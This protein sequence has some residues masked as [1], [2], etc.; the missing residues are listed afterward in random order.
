MKSLAPFFFCL[1][2]VASAPASADEFSDFRIPTHAWRSG[3]ADL[4]LSGHRDVADAGF[5]SDRNQSLVSDLSGRIT[6]LHDSDALQHSISLA[7]GLA[8]RTLDRQEALAY[9][10]T[11]IRQEMNSYTVQG[12]ET[13]RLDVG[14]RAYPWRRPL[15]FDVSASGSGQYGQSRS[16]RDDRDRQD[17]PPTREE[18]RATE[19]FHSYDYSVAG[20]AMA[21]W[22]RVRDATV[23][24]AIHVLEE[25]LQESGALARP[26]SREARERL[27]ALYFVGSDLAAAHD[28]PERFFWREVERVLREDGALS[29]HG[30]DPYS[31]MRIR[32]P[33]GAAPSPGPPRRTG[34]FVGAVGEGRHF[35]RIERRDFD[36]QRKVF[37]ADTLYLAESASGGVRFDQG[38]D[39]FLL[40]GQAEYHRPLGWRWQFDALAHVS[41]PVRPGDSGLSSWFSAQAS[42]L[43]ADRWGADAYVSQYRTYFSPRGGALVLSDDGWSVVYGA[44]VGYYLEDRTRIFAAVSERQQKSNSPSASGYGRFNRSSSL[45]VGVSYRFLGTFEAPGIMEPARLLR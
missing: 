15:G 25:R 26:L 19:A 41:A 31:V 2:L 33:Y 44:D 13:W 4:G 5:Q 9:P 8:V 18:R 35:H 11:S 14:A 21:G 37:L 30:L 36:A 32:E 29:E 6:R 38:Y 27:A 28:R 16:R 20:S 10:G 42:W 3:T 34:W 12:A 43:V 45:Q 22:G 7:L 39:A 40:G 23:V 24:Y 1:A 17:P